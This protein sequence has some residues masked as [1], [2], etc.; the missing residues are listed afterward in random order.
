MGR[1]DGQR[2][3]DQNK[4]QET[5]RPRLGKDHQGE[6]ASGGNGNQRPEA[7]AERHR[8]RYRA[9]S[10]RRQHHGRRQCK[11]GESA[12]APKNA[13]APIDVA[14]AKQEAGDQKQP[15]A[16]AGEAVGKPGSN[17]PVDKL[18]TDYSR[19]WDAYDEIVKDFSDEERAGLFWKN[20]ER[21]YRI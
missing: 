9:G 20:A 19:L 6:P 5:Q 21:Y 14:A 4:A 18:M 3:E 7:L 15:K 1:R 8:R 11:S 13:F 16:D 10:L 2:R 17:F 12:Q